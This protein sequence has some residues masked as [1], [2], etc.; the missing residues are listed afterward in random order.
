ML[1]RFRL[2]S[3]ELRYRYAVVLAEGLWRQ[4][5]PEFGRHLLSQVRRDRSH[6]LQAQLHWPSFCGSSPGRAECGL[7]APRRYNWLRSDS[8]TSGFDRHQWP[9][10]RRTVGHLR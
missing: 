2:R 7:T 8:G 6:L 3:G 1:G 10:F 5:N 4:A 9:N